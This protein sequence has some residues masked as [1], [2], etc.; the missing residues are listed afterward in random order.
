MNSKSN[1]V[2]SEVKKWRDFTFN[3]TVYDLSHLNA[4]QVEYFDDRDKD[5]PITYTFTVTYSFHCFTKESESEYH[6]TEELKQLIYDAPAESRPFNFERYELSKHL[7]S[8]IKSL[9]DKQTFV[10]HAGY[11]S[12]ATVKLLNLKGI[13]VDYLVIFKVFRE[14]KKLRLH[15][16]SAYPVYEGKGRMKKVRFLTLAKCLYSNQKLPKL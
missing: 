12:Y 11:N 3:S 6:S 4:H 9:S 7:P 15:V 16:T 5:N 2:R 14:N 1:I 13:E 10:G 8:I